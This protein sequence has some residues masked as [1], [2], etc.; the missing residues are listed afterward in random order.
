MTH[1][2]GMISLGCAKNQVNAEHMLWLLR[3]AGYEISPDPDG[4]ELVI[5]NTCG[6]IESAKTE[7]IDNILAM[8]QLKAEGRIQKILVTGCLAQRYQEE[9]LKELPEVDGVLG[10]G[11]YYDVA[12]AVGQILSGKRYK[13]FDDI[14]AEQ[15][16]DGRILTTPEYYAYLKIAEGCDNHCAYCVITKLRG[17]LRSRPMEEL[18]TEAEQLAADGVKELI[19][20]AQDTSR[21][22]IDRYGERKLPELLR[23]LCK[24]DGLHWIRVHYLY[25]DE[26]TDELIETIASEPKL[27]HYF[28]IPIQHVNANI[29]KKMNRRGTR[30]ELD[31]LFA[32]IRAR[33]PDAVFRTSLISGL[34][35]EGEAEFEEL[36]NWLREHK[37]ERVGAFVFSPEEGTAAARMDYP[38]QEVAARRA[39]YIN[40]LQSRIMDEYN[41]A[42]VGTALEVLCDGYDEENACWYGRSYADSPDIDGRVSFTSRTPVRVGDFVTVRIEG[43]RDGDLYGEVEA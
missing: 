14:N 5:V 2:I 29:L 32:K 30:Q 36:C 28:D 12:N 15:S 24:I 33:I 3:Q 40:E 11:S 4:A 34:P 39:E 6:F 26:M 43:A 23:E 37:L 8:A 1:T 19:V 10:T 22:G 9:I 41:A 16:E 20:V 31:A 13:R 35:G 42:R 27:V 38:E 18:V 25:P 7:A 21:Y 17:K